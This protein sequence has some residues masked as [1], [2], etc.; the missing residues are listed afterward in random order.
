MRVLLQKNT[1]IHKLKLLKMPKSIKIVPI[2]SKLQYKTLS[3]SS[4]AFSKYQYPLRTE[5]PTIT[6]TN[7]SDVSGPRGI[8]GWISKFI[9]F[10]DEED[11][12]NKLL[13]Q[14]Q[15]LPSLNPKLIQLDQPFLNQESG[16]I[17]KIKHSVYKEEE[18]LIETSILPNGI[19]VISQEKTLQPYITSFGIFS[20]MGSM[21]ETKDQTGLVDIMQFLTVDNDILHNIGGAC[22]S[23]SNRNLTV[24]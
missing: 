21:Y 17:T 7:A 4:D 6:R 8:K 24:S 19:K 3:T 13:E 10:D 2:K 20:K 15:S 22:Y 16:T 14:K 11:V 1:N 9:G 18:Q 23:T 5:A 12:K